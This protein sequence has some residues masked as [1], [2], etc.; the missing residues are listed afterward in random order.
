MSNDMSTPAA[1]LNRRG[2]LA[3][4]GGVVATT[5]LPAA[6]LAS[7]IR[8]E[9]S[10]DYREVIRLVGLIAKRW[11]QGPKTAEG[12]WKEAERQTEVDVQLIEGRLDPI[13][14]RVLSKQTPSS[15]DML[16]LAALMLHYSDCGF[17]PTLTSCAQGGDCFER[18]AL[19]LAAAVFKA[20]GMGG[21][22]V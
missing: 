3:A 13:E 9:P 18:R 12:D 7:P 15:D 6:S 4:V 10:A 2:L 17:E 1:G 16:I 20:T 21:V 19:N 14:D 5:A 22:H 8:F 11:E